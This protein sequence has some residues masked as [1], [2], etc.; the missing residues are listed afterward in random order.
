MD[1]VRPHEPEKRVGGVQR[2]WKLKLSTNNQP[3]C[4]KCKRYGNIARNCAYSSPQVKKTSAGVV[5]ILLRV[6]VTKDS[7]ESTG[8]A[9]E[10]T[11]N[12]QSEMKDDMLQLASG[13]LPVVMNCTAQADPKR[14]L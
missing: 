6:D 14:R 12:T 11:D 8:P 4:S 13:R 3:S 1:S 5:A 7:A 2:A 9:L 10:V